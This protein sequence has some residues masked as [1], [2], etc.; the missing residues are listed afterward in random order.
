[1]P[2]TALIIGGGIAGCV[3]ALTLSK[4]GIHCTIYELRDV[5]AT[6]G[7]AVNLTP[8]ALK[9]QIGRAHV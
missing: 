6:I 4:L 8:N 9:I 2:K 7:G 1:M 3:A 5:P